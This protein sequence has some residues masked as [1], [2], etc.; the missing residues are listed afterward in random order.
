MPP[1]AKRQINNLTRCRD[2]IKS[3]QGL[4]HNGPLLLNLAR[5]A[6]RMAKGPLQIDAAR[7]LHLLCVFPNDA[8]AHGGNTGFLNFSLYQSNG[9]IADASSRGEQDQ[10]HLILL[11]LCCD[12]PG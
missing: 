3:F 7:W 10:V 6:K 5:L 4:K 1:P 9:L 2:P 8:H 12:L 11:E